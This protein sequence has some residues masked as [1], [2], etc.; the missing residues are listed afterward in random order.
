MKSAPKTMKLIQINQWR[1]SFFQMAA[2]TNGCLVDERGR[3]GFRCVQPGSHAKRALGVLA[4][5]VGADRRAEEDRAGVDDDRVAG[6]GRVEAV[7]ATRRRA[8]LLLADAVVLR[9]VARALE[10]LRGLTERHAATEV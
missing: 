4:G 3:D 2:I 10:P 5:G 6:L 7:E 9:A 8:R 1:R